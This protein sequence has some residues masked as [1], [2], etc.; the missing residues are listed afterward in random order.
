M[1]GD[2][3]EGITLPEVYYPNAETRL[4]VGAEDFLKDHASLAGLK[5]VHVVL[6]YVFNTT[7]GLGYEMPEDL[8][9]QV[10]ARLNEHGLTM[11]TEEEMEITP[12]MPEIAIFPSYSGG[13]AAS[14]E[15]RAAMADVGDGSLCDCC[16]NSYWMAFKQSS[17]ILRRPN[18]QFKFGTWGTGESSDWCERRGEWMYDA[19]LEGIDKF[20]EDYQ[21]AETEKTPVV[22]A[23]REEVPGNCAQAWA[24]HLQVFNTNASNLTES[25]LPIIDRLV[26]TA[27]RCTNYSYVIE[28]HADQR[29]DEQYNQILTEARAAVI[30]DYLMARGVEYKRLK[31]IAFG[32]T[33]PLTDGT[34]EED[35]A[36]NRRVVIIP[37]LG[38]SVT[39]MVD[40]L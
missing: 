27:V 13:D 36:A 6:D 37:V 5:G 33:R 2:A 23:N 28:T 1:S 25:F 18:S 26:D 17:A 19:V 24:V 10:E 29:A 22:V 3:A 30:K 12:G 31:T 35:H 40:D 11:L 8:E 16:R 34:T 4:Q 7:K 14:D 39:A 38:R 32:E 9:Q 20:V 21:K 15:D